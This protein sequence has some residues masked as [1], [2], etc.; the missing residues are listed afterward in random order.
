MKN[1]T[2]LGSTWSFESETPGFI[3]FVCMFTEVHLPLW[4]WHVSPTLD[5]AGPIGSSLP[6]LFLSPAK[7]STSLLKNQVNW[8]SLFTV[9]YFQNQ[10]YL[11]YLCVYVRSS[12]LSQERCRGLGDCAAWAFHEAKGQGNPRS[13]SCKPQRRQRQREPAHPALTP[14]KISGGEG[15]GATHTPRAEPRDGK[16]LHHW[17]TDVIQ[18]PFI[19]YLGP[20]VRYELSVTSECFCLVTVCS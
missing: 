7:V 3:W 2:W 8:S 17:G 14:G 11:Y 10:M 12:I 16:D 1:T 13:G 9:I 18:P 5:Q 19:N 15:A 4:L 6:S 20:R